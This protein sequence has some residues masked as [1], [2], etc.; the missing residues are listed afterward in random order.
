MVLFVSVFFFSRQNVLI[1][2]VFDKMTFI[3]YVF[4][5]WWDKIVWIVFVCCQSW[6][7]L[8]SVGLSSRPVLYQPPT[9]DKRCDNNSVKTTWES[10]F[11]SDSN[12][13]VWPCWDEVLQHWN[14]LKPS[15]PLFSFQLVALHQ[16][17]PLGQNSYSH[18]AQNYVQL[19]RQM[20]AS[21]R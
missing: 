13:F 8:S 18:W 2:F 21:L 12:C 1:V 20:N 3:V 6:G 10:E 9:I 11:D 16:I 14:I 5:S 4:L 17:L 15:K 7:F 19:Q